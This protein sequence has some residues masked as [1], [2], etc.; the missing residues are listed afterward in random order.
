MTDRTSFQDLR[1][2]LEEAR[3]FLHSFTKGCRGYTPEDGRAA[4]QRLTSLCARMEEGFSAGAHARVVA[5]LMAEARAQ[6]ADA[7]KRLTLLQR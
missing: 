6:I 5:P 2:E 3:S 1:R 7:E 4:I